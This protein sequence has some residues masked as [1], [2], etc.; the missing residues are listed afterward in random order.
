MD[1]KRNDLSNILTEKHFNKLGQRVRRHAAQDFVRHARPKI[2]TMIEKAEQLAAEQ[3]Q[4]IID[5]ANKQMQTLQQSELRRLRA[6]AEVNPNIRQ[7]EIDHLLAEAD[8]LQHHLDSAHIK[9]E[10][11]RVAVITD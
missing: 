6:L 8:E 3:E 2:V 5:T 4:S 11:V 7:E 9:L 10:A 1:N